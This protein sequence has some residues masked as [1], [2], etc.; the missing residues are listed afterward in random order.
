MEPFKIDLEVQFDKLARA[1]IAEAV[2]DFRVMPIAK[3]EQDDIRARLEQALPDYPNVK[4]QR[5]WQTEVQMHDDKPPATVT[6]D[7]GLV[8]VIMRSADDKQ[9]AQFQHDGF[10]FS[11]LQPYPGWRDFYTEAMRLW[12]VYKSQTKAFG[13]NRLGLR[14]I[15][16]IDLQTAGAGLL[17]NVLTAPP[18]SPSGVNLPIK[19][20]FTQE[21][22][23]VPDTSFTINLI[24][25]LDAAS[26]IIDI[27]VFTTL[28][29]EDE[30]AMNRQ[31]DEMRWL[32]NKIFF[33]S[34]T[35]RAKESMR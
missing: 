33:A 22:F 35:Q 20:F 7:H 3:W 4:S 1:P 32:K 6:Q 15:N 28:V 5:R 29:R 13:V 14:F 26:I 8:G 12:Q 30:Q 23:G 31:I 34:I 17:E 2:L 21:A 11:R 19:G 9:V 16:Q 24:R 10:T 25:A 18:M 27:D